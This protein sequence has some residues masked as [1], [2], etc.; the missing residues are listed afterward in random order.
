MRLDIKKISNILS[1]DKRIIFAY[2]YGSSLKQKE[3]NDIDIAIYLNDQNIDSVF[4]IDIQIALYE[5]T[6]IV[7][8]F[9]DVK[10]INDLLN[11]GD[12]FT[13]IY[14]KKIFE[15][16]CLLVDNDFDV[17]TNYIEKFNIKYFECEGMI[18]QI[19]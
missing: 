3:Y 7:A 6:N 9:F 5:H 13:L 10:I 15:T 2:L 14:L 19:I 1:K 16:N 12:I 8:D 17:R 18:N 4:S 11:I